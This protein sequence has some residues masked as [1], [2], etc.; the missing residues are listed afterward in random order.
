MILFQNYDSEKEPAFVTPWTMIHILTG[1]LFGHFTKILGFKPAFLWYLVLH[2]LYEIKD[3]WMEQEDNSFL[4]CLGDQIFGILGFLFGFFSRPV[5]V[6]GS[7]VLLGILFF[8]PVFK[9]KQ[10]THY[11]N[12]FLDILFSRG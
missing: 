4:N 2:T 10:H 11:Q 8:L 3:I 12:R 5:Y 6:Y 9:N 7:S 1:I